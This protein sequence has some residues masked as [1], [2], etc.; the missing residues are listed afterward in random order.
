[1][2]IRC[3]HIK[4]HL[5]IG[6]QCTCNRHHTI[7]P[8]AI[9]I[10]PGSWWKQLGWTFLNHACIFMHTLPIHDGVWFLILIYFVDL[11]RMKPLT[12]IMIERCNAGTCTA[13]DATC[14]FA[15]LATWCKGLPRML[16]QGLTTYTSRVILSE[17]MR[18]E[19]KFQSSGLQALQDV[20]CISTKDHHHAFLEIDLCSWIGHR[21]WSLSQ[22]ASIA[23]VKNHSLYDFRWSVSMCPSH[24][25]SQKML[26]SI[27]TP[28][29]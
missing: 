12:L 8:I 28:V 6:Q 17:N 15:Q 21:H 29:C 14:Y 11:I 23:S 4:T 13:I 2:K 5:R 26:R 25:H 7:M 1:M 27:T 24:D 3:S 20:G 9:G 16:K 18:V 22:G 19:L 10:I